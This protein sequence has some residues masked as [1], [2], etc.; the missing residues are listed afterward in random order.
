MEPLDITQARSLVNKLMD[1]MP[2]VHEA[3]ARVQYALDMGINSDVWAKDYD[4]KVAKLQE[5]WKTTQ[6]KYDANRLQLQGQLDEL[7]LMIVAKR[8]AVQ[9]EIDHLEQKLKDHQ[10]SINTE[11]QMINTQHQKDVD[12]LTAISSRAKLDAESAQKDSA[13]LIKNLSD[14]ADTLRTEIKTLHD[15]KLAILNQFKA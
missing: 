8:Q 12:R 11:I 1:L 13:I 3:T 15:T 5:D 7:D 2:K 14:H 9:D 4:A 10:Q 6:E